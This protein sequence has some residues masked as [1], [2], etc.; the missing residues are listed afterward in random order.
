MD[1]P[2]RTVDKLRE[3][4]E[5]LIHPGKTVKVEKWSIQNDYTLKPTGKKRK[6]TV[7]ALY[8]FCFTVLIGNHVESFRHN[9]LFGDEEMRVRV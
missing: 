8:P 9:E 1:R 5:L 4:A 6:G 7:I 2:E 3:M